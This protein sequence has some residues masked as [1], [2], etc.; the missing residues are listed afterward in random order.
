MIALSYLALV[1]IGFEVYFALKNEQGAAFV[2][3]F[4]FW[5]VAIAI[6]VYARRIGHPLR[7]RRGRNRQ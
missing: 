6:Y 7:L 4:F 1:P 5:A 3:S 2:T